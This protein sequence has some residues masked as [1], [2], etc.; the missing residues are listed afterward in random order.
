MCAS[1]NVKLLF[2]SSS[3]TDCELSI[4]YLLIKIIFWNA[5]LFL[6][7]LH[8][9]LIIFISA[10]NLLKFLEIYW[11]ASRPILKVNIIMKIKRIENRFE[12]RNQNCNQLYFPELEH[13]STT[14]WSCF[15]YHFM[16]YDPPHLCIEIE[17]LALRMNRI[18]RIFNSRKTK[19]SSDHN[20]SLFRH[21]QTSQNA[22]FH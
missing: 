10:W 14:S 11:F 4:L 8:F 6:C 9:S 22:N 2:F 13:S 20:Y 17:I 1:S 21:F 7:R 18:R 15:Y 16:K 5:K 3:T 12:S 19:L